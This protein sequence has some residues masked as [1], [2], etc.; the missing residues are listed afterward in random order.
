MTL[1]RIYASV[2]AALCTAGQVLAASYYVSPAATTSGAVLVH[3]NRTYTVGTTAFPTLNELLAAS[4]EASSAVYFAP[5]TYPDAVNIN[6]EGLKLYG[7][8]AYQDPRA[9]TRTNPSSITGRWTVTANNVTIN[10]F[11]FTGAGQVYNNTATKAAPLTGLKVTFCQVSGS[12]LARAKNVA[13]IRLGSVVDDA[14]APTAAVQ[15]RYVD[16]SVVHSIFKGAAAPHFIQLC[17]ASGTTTIDDN[18]FFNGGRSIRLDNA[19][20]TMYI[21]YNKFTE[22]GV[23]NEADG[24]DFCI[25]INRS[26][27]SGTNVVNIIAN[28]FKNCIGATSLYPLI[29]FYTG[30]EG[31][32]D[33]VMPKGTTINIKN[34]VFRGKKQIHADYNYVYYANKGTGAGIT[35]DIS[36]NSFDN[37]N[38][39]MAWCKNSNSGELT[40]YFADNYCA[41]YPS[42]STFG[43]WKAAATTKAVSVLQSF[44][45]DEKTGDAYYIQVSGAA[46]SGDPKPLQLSHWIKSSN[47]W[48]GVKVIWAGHGSNMATCRIGGHVYI[49]M[50]GNATLPSG[51]S[52]TRSDG[53]SWFRYI[54]GST[55]DVRKSSFTYDGTT[56]PIKTFV[57]PDHRGIYPAVDEVSR[58]LVLR[59]RSGSSMRFV[60]YDLDAFLSDPAN[61]TA[62]RNFTI[63]KGDNPSG[64]NAADK[65]HNTWDHQGFTVSGDYLYILEGV[66]SSG[67]PDGEGTPP[68]NG[69][70]TIFLDC[71]NWRKKTFV[72][73]KWLN[74]STLLSNV[75][76]EP[77]GIKVARNPEGHAE[78]LLG[79]AV[80]NSGARKCAI[81]KYTPKTDETSATASLPNGVHTTD[82]S[83]IAFTATNLIDPL[84]QTVTITNDG[85]NGNV[86]CLCSGTK[87]LSVSTSKTNPWNAT[88]TAVVTYKPD[89][90][91]P[92]ATG[93]LRVSSPK[94]VDLVI[95]V[96]MTNSAASA[97][98]DIQYDDQ[99]QAIDPE[100]AEFYNLQG[101]RIDFPRPG[102]LLIKRLGTQI[103]K[104]IYRD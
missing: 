73:R 4:P 66:S 13:V 6:V 53:C 9:A 100:N 69:K 99:E 31:A 49:F 33:C 17:G 19:T 103:Q 98:A 96:T 50:G 44:D 5:G 62:L 95:P 79:I 22:V 64:L 38:Y 56:Y 24:G 55:V 34:N 1:N 94:A 42:K 91:E 93:Y 78:L 89:K 68:I 8:N 32:T 102:Q 85:I 101:Q 35:T 12:T 83:S 46:T 60:V 11:D 88:T 47:T 77:E 45:V 29:R 39:C 7:A 27:Y 86:K 104:I 74:N 84:S 41:L 26:C 48:S 43:T 25:S 23:D 72:Y 57:W 76:G 81:Y 61:A 82:L 21:R 3:K 36:G 59:S 28:D 71:Y 52:E 2:I 30:E 58:L 16:I 75:H 63:H 20:G 15:A 92:S 67:N 14:A 80:G 97:V 37:R 70:P 10:G 90:Y 54:G 87:N 18:K 65:G 51:A 40:K